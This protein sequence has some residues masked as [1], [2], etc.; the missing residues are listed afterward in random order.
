[1]FIE[2]VLIRGYNHHPEH[3][4][5]LSRYL[6][7][8]PVRINLIPYNPGPNALF[9][10][11]THEEVDRFRQALIAEGMFVRLRSTRGADIQAACGQLGTKSLSLAVLDRDIS[12]HQPRLLS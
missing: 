8:L 11:P 5:E 7:G 10:A 9:K 6:R 12:D 2:Y 1:L 3:A 4:L